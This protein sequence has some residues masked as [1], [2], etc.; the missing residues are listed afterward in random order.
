M[1]KLISSFLACTLIV[2]SCISAFS[3][4][5]EDSEFC[6]KIVH[7][8]DIHA[9]VT[10]N[11]SGGI[12]G[13]S[14]L[15]TL[16]DEH[17]QNSDMSLV[18]DSGDLFHGQ[19]IATLVQG[20]SIAKLIGACGYDAMTA[21][22]HDWN[23]GKDRLKELVKITGENDVKDFKMLTGNVINNDGTKFFDDEFLI[24]TTE[25][26]GETLKVGVF[27]VID[28]TIYSK[29]SPSNVSGLVFT[30]MKQY[31]Q[32]AVNYLEEQRCQLIIGLTHCYN[33]MQL[34]SE[35]D[36]VD[37]W[38]A[39]HEHI[40]VNQS[41]STPSGEQS[42]VI[43][44]GYYLYQAGLLELDFDLNDNNEIE[45]LE[46]KTSNADYS[47]CAELTPDSEVQSVL[48]QINDEQSVILNQ[49][50]GPSPVDLDGVWENLRIDETNLGRAVTD[51][52]LL[53]TGAD[54]AFENAGGIRA[55]IKQGDVL[56]GDIIGVLPYGNY[57]V[58]KQITG[59]DLLEILETS[60]DIQ[61]KSIAANDS[62]EYD[63]W[64]QNS[65]SYLQIGGMTVEY[66]ISK[67]YGERVE[68]AF[69]GGKK[70]ENDSFYTVATN[71]FVAVSSVYPQLATKE[72]SGEYSACDE[73]LINFFKQSDEK[74]LS[75]VTTP[76]MIQTTTPVETVPS[77][78]ETLPTESTTVA[79]A[80]TD[81]TSAT[82]NAS[83]NSEN[84]T[85]TPD[86]PSNGISTGSEIAI[87][88]IVAVIIISAA[89]IYLFRRKRII[90]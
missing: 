29:T 50:V 4:T 59:Q 52:Y 90:K 57:I 32:E 36:G 31:S 65:G 58:T 76:R 49:V 27:G 14:K 62:G 42:L 25:K 66:N 19:S 69:V 37:L 3:A 71:N 53:V 22:N 30:D 77:T 34:A 16:I 82:S 67:P 56:Y 21:G 26:D 75:S 1:K 61:K 78:T 23:Y 48:N 88:S 11:E 55:S 87:F 41:V 73:A 8:N 64:P 47:V 39:G 85:A 79:T 54:V 43:E 35:V 7:T 18:L 33:P 86:T 81:P 15:K 38:L 72:E 10:E 9:R 5:E 84:K 12:I 24:K 51:A 80:A 83:A 45:N 70:L 20:E 17:A 60:I 2:L 6:L 28:P 44:N 74:I 63:A 13:V 89:C 46:Y 40:N 68:S